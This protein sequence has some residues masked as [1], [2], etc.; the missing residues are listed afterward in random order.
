MKN[1]Q[2]EIFDMS[3]PTLTYAV[4]SD[5]GR[6]R[7]NNEDNLYA[8]GITL[9]AENR[10]EPFS[11]D[12]LVSAPCLFAV[13]D[14]MGGE[15]DGEFASMSAVTELAKFVECIN[16]AEQPDLIVQEYVT[17]TNTLLCDAMR[18]RS[19]RMGTTLALAA[20][21]P[22]G[23]HAYS[24]GDS[25]IYALC[26]GEFR[27]ISS[28][29]TLVAPKIKMGL[30]TDEQARQDKDWHKLTAY[31]G[32][33]E[34]ELE[35][36]ADVL[37]VL[38]FENGLRLLMC[39]DG[40]TDMVL[41]N[42]IEEILC[43]SLTATEAADVLL[44]EALDNGCKDNITIIVLDIPPTEPQSEQQ[45]KKQSVFETAKIAVTELPK[46]ITRGRGVR[47]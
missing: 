23:V 16:V 38:S 4:R 41:D 32:V 7:E 2:M 37:P 29:H 42:R 30:L 46:L 5:M 17:K 28:D 8:C 26:G 31:L 36:C 18:E 25:R 19:V 14:G 21:R 11:F 44:K 12:G 33:F 6:K 35:I 24:I 40:L 15:A 20:V 3:M 27:Q 13:C 9:T 1:K 43:A 22:D 34:D 10:N 39:S 45:P 47:K